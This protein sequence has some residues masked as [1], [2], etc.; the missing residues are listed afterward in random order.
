MCL[1]NFWPCFHMNWQEMSFSSN[2][3]E[4]SNLI[5]KTLKASLLARWAFNP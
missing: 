4:Q 2:L 3:N 5:L 1:V